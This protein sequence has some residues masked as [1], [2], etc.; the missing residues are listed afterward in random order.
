MK[1]QTL[2]ANRRTVICPIHYPVTIITFV[3]ACAL[4]ANVTYSQVSVKY[5]IFKR[6]PLGIDIQTPQP[7]TLVPINIHSGS[8][9]PA[10]P[11]TQYQQFFRTPSQ[12]IQEQNLRVMQQHSALSN[13]VNQR[14]EILAEVQD[15]ILKLELGREYQEWA[16]KTQ[17]YRDAYDGLLMLN[18]D[19]F[20]ITQAVYL[21]ENAWLEGKYSFTSLKDRLQIEAKIIKQQLK[22]QKLSTNDNL[23]LNYGIQKRFKIGGQYYDAKKKKTLAIKPFKYDFEDYKGEKDYRQMFTIKML[24]TGKGQCHSMPLVYL[25]IAEELGTKAWLSLAPQHS[26]IRFLDSKDRLLNFEATNGNVVSTSWLHQSGYINAAAIK[27][28]IYLDTLSQR[29]LYSQM[30]ADLLL[31]YLSKF[32][33][34]GFAE[35]VRQKILQINP[36]NMTA[37]IVDAQLKANVA[38]HKINSAGRPLEKDLHNYPDAYQAY[39]V[40]QQ[41]FDNID[42]LGYQDMPAEAYQR[43]LK[44]IEKEKQK[45]EHK[46]LQEKMQR[47]IDFLKKY[48]PKSTVTDRTRG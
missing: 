24:I 4:Y 9:L 47:E 11:P 20:S 39:L 42:R 37:I 6:N 29:E 46:E 18:P 30:L 26:Y 25:M 17:Y 15:D 3:A 23:A 16:A 19:S 38:L 14:D 28:R 12:D 33:Y 8:I 40:M 10:N 31:G 7:A 34:D 2:S 22:S 45:Q 1:I 21:V 5:D 44:S 41:S 32:R 48:K 13:N 27:N 43:W 35:A 36:N